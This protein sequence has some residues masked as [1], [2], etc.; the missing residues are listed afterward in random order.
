M[1]S[2]RIFNKVLTVTG[3]LTSTPVQTIPGIVA[4]AAYA[5]GD[6]F[7]EKFSL[8]VPKQGVISTFVFIDKDDEGITKEL[9]ILNRDFT[10]VADNAVFDISDDSLVNSVG[11]I[12][13]DA[14]DF[15]DLGS[16]QIATITPALWY[17]APTGSLYCQFVTRG[18]DNIAAGS[19]PQFFMVIS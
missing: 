14:V 1:I 2:V 10:A 16:N 4:G 6:A 13:I 11:V 9:I 3:R 15:R 17:E 7:G 18:A 8:R 19:M 5:S 12:D